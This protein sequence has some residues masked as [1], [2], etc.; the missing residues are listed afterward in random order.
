M[1]AAVFRPILPA[2]LKWGA[3]ALAVAALLLGVRRAGRADE[4][5]AQAQRRDAN[6]E[7]AHAVNRAL[8]RRPD[9]AAADE[10]RRTW[11]RD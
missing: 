10:L 1:I 3:A 2:L 8:D 4:R 6:L 9:G 5:L 11:S 7:T